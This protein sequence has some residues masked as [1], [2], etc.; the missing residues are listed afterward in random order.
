MADKLT[1]SEISYSLIGHKLS[2]EIFSEEAITKI[3]NLF[4]MVIVLQM[5][6]FDLYTMK[7]LRYLSD[8]I[9]T[10]RV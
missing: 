2:V 9:L 6:K 1:E 3:E 4:L 10:L 8:L 7:M 5:I